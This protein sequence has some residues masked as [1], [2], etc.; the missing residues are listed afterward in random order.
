MRVYNRFRQCNKT[1]EYLQ[2]GTFI[3]MEGCLAVIQHDNSEWL[4]YCVLSDY[5]IV[6]DNQRFKTI[7]LSER[8]KVS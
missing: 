2:F 5:A 6:H 4:S 7:L 8:V 1:F 3:K